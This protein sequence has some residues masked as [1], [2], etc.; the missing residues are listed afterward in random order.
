MSGDVAVERVV[1][2]SV[3]VVKSVSSYLETYHRYLAEETH[4]YNGKS[5]ILNSVQ[6]GM[7]VLFVCLTIESL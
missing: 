2:E 3:F 6:V 5:A 4:Q 1:V 7:N